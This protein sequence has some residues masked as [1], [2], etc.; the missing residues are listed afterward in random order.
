MTGQTTSNVGKINTIDNNKQQINRFWTFFKAQE[1]DTQLSDQ[2]DRLKN[3][4]VQRLLKTQNRANSFP[5]RRPDQ[6]TQ[7]FRGS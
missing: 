7:L 3:V 6:K 4:V 5:I 1:W 2:A